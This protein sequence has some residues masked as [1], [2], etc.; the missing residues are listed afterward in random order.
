MSGISC[1]CA[2]WSRRTQF[3]TW[4]RCPTT[5][6]SGGRRP[7]PS[8]SQRPVSRSRCFRRSHPPGRI[9][10]GAPH[11]HS[12]STTRGGRRARDEQGA[13]A[14]L[15]GILTIVMFTITA[16]VVDLGLA[17]VVRREAQVASDASSLAAATALYAHPDYTHGK[18]PPDFTSAIAA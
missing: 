16:L 15:V 6:S 3:P 5:G 8:R 2:P 7:C 17:R 1:W 12:V 4:C 9:G 11:E 18:P 10:P 13:V 14:V